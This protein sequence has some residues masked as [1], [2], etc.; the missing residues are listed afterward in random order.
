V[1]RGAEGYS[2]VFDSRSRVFE[3]TPGRNQLTLTL[4]QQF[5][6]SKLEAQG[7]L[8]LNEV[9]D[10][11]KLPR[12][13]EGQTAGWVWHPGKIV[14]FSVEEAD[15]ADW[16]TSVVLKFNVDGDIMDELWPTTS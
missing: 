14:V 9:F 12:T 2:A 11:L 10:A 1:N 8:F 5:M 15:K 6:S 13:R 3:S 16:S 7:H 4:F